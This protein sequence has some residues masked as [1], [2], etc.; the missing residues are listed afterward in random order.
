[1][2]AYAWYTINRES[3]DRLQERIAEADGRRLRRQP[4]PQHVFQRKRLRLAM[5]QLL[6]AAGT[7]LLAERPGSLAT[8]GASTAPSAHA[9]MATAPTTEAPAG[10]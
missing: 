4:Q 5:G 6:I 8:A 1:M 2:D 7:R 3:H 10:E 9:D